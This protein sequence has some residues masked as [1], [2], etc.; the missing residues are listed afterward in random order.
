MTTF[1][2][3]H[4][5]HEISEDMVRSLL[6]I[7]FHGGSNY[8]MYILKYEFPPNVDK[9]HP[10]DDFLN[11][12][13][14]AV[15]DWPVECLIPLHRGGGIVIEEKKEDIRHILTREKLLNGLDIMAKKYPTWFVHITYGK[16]TN[17]TADLFLQCCLFEDV[18][19]GD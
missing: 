13:K 9:H 6:N 2:E 5:V 12:G 11:G 8:W 19:F 16:P 14:F 3:V 17:K 15:G 1:K 10:I 4:V 18:V 7:A